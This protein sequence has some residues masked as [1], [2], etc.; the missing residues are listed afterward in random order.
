MNTKIKP[1]I[2]SMILQICV[3]KP[4]NPVLYM[5]NWLEKTG[6]INKYGLTEEEVKELKELRSEVTKF[7]QREKDEKKN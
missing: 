2:E 7:K 3:E 4:E 6:G 5:I 1:I